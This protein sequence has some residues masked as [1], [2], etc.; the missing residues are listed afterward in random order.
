LNRFFQILLSNRRLKL[1][2]AV[3]AVITWIYVSEKSYTVRDRIEVPITFLAP[4]K[5]YILPEKSADR[6]MLTLRGPTQVMNQLRPGSLIVEID[7]ARKKEA[8]LAVAHDF[9]RPVTLS[10]TRLD[11]RNLPGDVEVT[12]IS[13]P[14]VTVTL[15]EIGD[16]RLA[17]EPDLVGSPKVGTTQHVYASPKDVIVSGPKSVLARLDSIR[18]LPIP[19]GDLDVGKWTPSRPLNRTPMVDGKPIG[20]ENC[21]T[22]PNT[23]AV[24]I[25]IEVVPIEGTRVVK[26]VPLEVRG[27]PGLGYK[28]L[29]VDKNNPVTSIPEVEIKG[30][31]AD[32]NNP[33]LRAYVDLTDITDP[34][35]KSE[36]TREV[37]FS[38]APGIEVATK[39]PS[40][41]VQIFVAPE[42]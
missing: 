24:T 2:S 22:T 7:I 23:D 20:P 1:L 38:A 3:L 11:I 18:T 5:K 31:Q 21:L 10:I 36:V 39:P 40:V 16:K 13:L 28:V 41:V 19:I 14:S 32:L 12:Y 8:E 37:G 26:N 9:P 17:V 30:P 25:W 29:T 42:E 35:L 15:D 34:K 4:A 6:V 33:A 27:L